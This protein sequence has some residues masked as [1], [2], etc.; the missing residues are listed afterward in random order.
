MLAFVFLRNG[1]RSMFKEKVIIL[2]F[3]LKHEYSALTSLHTNC[4]RYTVRT[5]SP[6]RSNYRS[7]P[8][9]MKPPWMGRLEMRKCF[10]LYDSHYHVIIGPLDHRPL[11]HI[12]MCHMRELHQRTKDTTPRCFPQV[13][14]RTSIFANL[15]H[16]PI[17][18]VSYIG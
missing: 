5:T 17:N 13:H 8:T 14:T 11:H 7:F 18:H 12:I 4:I 2:R 6:S 9:S 10:P 16:P 3:P 15:T 1:A